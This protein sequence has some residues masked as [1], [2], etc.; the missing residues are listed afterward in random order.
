[1]VANELRVREVSGIWPWDN[2]AK[3]LVDSGKYV[4]E[5]EVG[6]WVYMEVSRSH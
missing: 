4:V 5:E 6:T 1:M 2:M 3:C